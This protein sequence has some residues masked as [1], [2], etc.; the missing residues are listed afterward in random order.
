MANQVAQ[1]YY[2]SDM[3]RLLLALIIFLAAP[4]LSYSKTVH[5]EFA[6]DTIFGEKTKEY[7]VP[8]SGKI[9]LDVYPTRAVRPMGI[10][11]V[12]LRSSDGQQWN[13]YKSETL[14]AGALEKT[15][16]TKIDCDK[17]KV[18]VIVRQLSAFEFKL[19]ATKD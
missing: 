16:K 17:C 6:K 2:I 19:A 8:L 3:Y 11:I 18:R 13:T 5:V 10:T 15:Y 7:M 9:V 14:E 4:A 12:Y 1:L